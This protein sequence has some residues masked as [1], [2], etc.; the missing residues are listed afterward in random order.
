MQRP[1]LAYQDATVDAYDLATGEGLLQHQAGL[2]VVVRLAIGRV[3]DGTVDD[4]E[5]GVRGRQAL[6]AFLLDGIG[7]V[8]L[9][10]RRR[11]RQGQQAVRL[12][13]GRAEG[14]EL[15]LHVVQVVV[16]DVVGIETLYVDDRIVRTEACQRVDVRI[17]IVAYQ[18]ACI[19]PEHALGLEVGRKPL[20]E[21]FLAVERVAVLRHQALGGSQYGALSVALDR[22]AFQ[23]LVTT[24]QIGGFP[25]FQQVVVLE[26]FAVEQRLVDLIV[27][28]GRKFHAPT[29]EAVI[30]EYERA[31]GTADG[32]EAMVACPGIVGRTFG[33]D[34]ARQIDA[35]L[36]KLL[37][38]VVRLGRD[39]EQWLAARNFAG[40]GGEALL[41]RLEVRSPV[42]IGMRP[43]ELYEPLR[44]PFGWKHRYE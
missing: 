39:N 9:E 6:I 5:V 20:L 31:I 25:E 29:V 18:E 34:H 44:F 28:V 1:V 22:S 2:F 4:E 32:Q 35:T 27:E 14:V 37:L 7:K 10:D 43:C 19:E 17:G 11:H 38:D 16:M 26:H 23:N 24:V 8:A 30:V 21:A 41:G 3:E 13:V 12:A 33:N 15:L 40:N 36:A 42:G